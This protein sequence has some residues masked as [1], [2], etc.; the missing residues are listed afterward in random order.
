MKDYY[1]LLGID[2]NA[3]KKDVKR[4][5][6]V[7]ATKYH[8]DKNSDPK[9]A[10][11]F[12]VITEAYNILSKPKSRAKY[13]LYRWQQ[14]KQQKA[15][16]DEFTVVPP[17]RESTRTR[18]NKAQKKRSIS[19]H[20]AS[21]GIGKFLQL[22]KESFYICSRYYLH[23]LGTTLLLVILQEEVR[24][25]FMPADLSLFRI[26]F[27]LF[28]AGVIAF[29]L[30]WIFRNFYESF[31]LDAHAFSVFYRISQQKAVGYLMAG[32]L[33]VLMLYLYLLVVY[34]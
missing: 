24:H 7:L 15:A 11:K 25:L 34:F 30:L 13:D 17:L 4:N 18:R 9:A 20:Q 23:I 12:I 33:V 3:T 19:Y 22:A 1:S 31:K 6:R 21:S 5:Y 28:F 32:L 29:C 10:E 8:P 14:Q 26:G 16:A 27:I 2:K